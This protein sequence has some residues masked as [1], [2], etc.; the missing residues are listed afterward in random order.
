MVV[1]SQVAP[2]NF[3]KE[4]KMKL[5]DKIRIIRKARGLSQEG[6]GEKL[7]RTSKYGISRQSVSDWENGKAEPKLDNIRDLSDVLQ[8][9]FDALLD[10]SIDLDDTDIL[11]QVLQNSHDE[12]RTQVGSS[13]R[14][15]LYANN[16]SVRS[17]VCCI[18]FCVS[19]L[20]AGLFFALNAWL[21]ND[22]IVILAG[23]FSGVALGSISLSI[24][25]I[26]RALR[27]KVCHYIGEINQSHLI[28]KTYRTALNTLVIPIDKI[29]KIEL[30]SKQKRKHGEVVIT[31]E[32]RTKPVTLIDIME[33][34]KMIEV[35][36]N[37]SSYNSDSDFIKI[38]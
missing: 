29:R 38:F 4:G 11:A 20:L 8:V 33:P 17:F 14:Y 35:Y 28:I 21:N 15:E 2:Y 9:S 16:L 7:S 30:G 12:R 19:I 32:G 18:I 13:F 37:I 22:F 31:I 5:S 23:I 26:M 6:L 34:G 3:A 25:E 1:F 24:I 10:E 36:K 27:G